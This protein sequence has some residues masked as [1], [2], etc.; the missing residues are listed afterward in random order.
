MRVQVRLIFTVVNV[1]IGEEVE[2]KL[3][4]RI[5][6]FFFFKTVCPSVEV[7]DFVD[8]IDIDCYAERLRAEENE[9]IRQIVHNEFC[10]V[11]E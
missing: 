10:C 7:D 9:C 11:S 8:S 5:D 1:V 4:R 3:A 6:C 2:H